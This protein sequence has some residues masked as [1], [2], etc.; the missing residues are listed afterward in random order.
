MKIKTTFFSCLAIM[1]ILTI[2]Y[3]YTQARQKT[4]VPSAKIGIVSIAKISGNCTKSI[5]HMRQIDAEQNKIIEELKKLSEQIKTEEAVL[6]A[7]KQDSSDYLAQREKCINMRASLEAKQ[8]I[9]KEQ[10]IL[11]QYKWRKKFY[12]DIL[13]ITSELAEQKGLDVVL[14]KD[15]IDVSVLSINE[16]NQTMIT[17]KVLYSGGCVDITDEVTAKLDKE[18]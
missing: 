8:T 17:H 9:S 18:K 2:G 3:E 1:I 6:I 12:Q 15:E 14:E 4:N 7:L 11:K 5:A 10:S 16:L 13:R